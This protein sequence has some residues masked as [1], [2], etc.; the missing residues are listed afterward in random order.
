MGNKIFIYLTLNKKIKHIH[1]QYNIF[2]KFK[3]YKLNFSFMDQILEL[4]RSNKPTLFLGAGCS[5]GIG[6]PS[7]NELLE[8]ML[9][10]FSDVDFLNENNFFDVYED[11]LDSE[12][13]SRLELEEFVKKQLEGLFPR[14]EH[15][16]L[17]SFPWKCIFT[18]NY[19][20]VLERIP[21]NK[22][23]DRNLRVVKENDPE[24]NLRRHDLLH[25]VKILGSID[26][27]YGEEGN[28]I[29]SRTDYHTSFQRRKSY[30]KI[31]GDCVREGP[32]IFLGYS[33]EDN[34]VFDI[35][36]ELRE[37]IG[38]EA[39]RT[40][41]A[42]FPNQ[43]SKRILRLF[44]KYNIIHIEGTFEEFIS[45]TKTKLIEGRDELIYAEKTIHIHGFPIDIPNTI[46]RP[47]REYF[48]F[49]NSSSWDS[50]LK[51]IN[52]F[53]DGED[54]SFYPYTQNWDFER[55]LYSF[56][57]DINPQK[58]KLYGTNVNDGLKKHLF[59]NI[60]N[61]VSDK[62]EITIL[63]GPAGC[64]KT[65]IL[66]RLAFDWYT[67]AG[68]PVII[69]DPQGPYIDFKQVDTFISYLEEKFNLNSRLKNKWPRPRT[70]IICD[71]AASLLNTYLEMFDYLTSRGKS[72][73]MI[74]SDRENLLNEKDIKSYT[75]YS[76]PETIS[77]DEITRFKSYLY[78]TNLVQTEADV[79]GLLDNPEINT[80]FFALMYT[81]IDESKRPLNQI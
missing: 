72:I 78:S 65:I 18:T 49:L 77:P 60:N 71:H 62:N 55:E 68:L 4:F 70:L 35:L 16:K 56:E 53:F 47:A 24:I 73:S 69:M 75:T 45:R 50:N 42:V 15:Y 23:Q 64:G 26:T 41:Y 37:E 74:L 63:T 48:T 21:S 8:T 52:K 61:P 58:C 6:G 67:F 14:E 19:D 59:K 66:K 31:L 13:H 3:K 51:K 10:K 9:N 17:L 34:L 46:E 2:Q 25:Y 30:Y 28:P 40:L 81:I 79:Y 12:N 44:N 76:M 5:M 22:F 7:G 54:N 38:P 27:S 80:S 11:I 29:L 1:T 32:V 36:A 39:V 57:R 33:F 20:T 43:P